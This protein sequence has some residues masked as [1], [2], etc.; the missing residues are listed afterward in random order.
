MS[1]V[2]HRGICLLLVLSMVLGITLIPN[3]LGITAG[4]AST[5]I[6]AAEE[7]ILPENIQDGCTLQCWNWSL[8][9][10]EANLG[11]IAN[12]GYTSIQ[13]SP[14][15]AVKEP[16]ENRP[17]N[18][19]WILYQPVE[20]TINESATHAIGTRDELIDLCE[21]A[22]KYGIKVIMDVVCNHMANDGDNVL[23]SLID[24]DILEDPLCWHD[25]TT[26]SWD[27]SSRYNITQYCM[28]GLPDL[29][30]ANAKIQNYCLN[31]LKDYIDCGVDG[32]RFDGAKQIETPSDDSSF[33]S[34]FWPTVVNGAT[35]YAQQTR[36][37]ALYCYGEIL[38]DADDNNSLP[39]SAYTDYMSVTD[40][41]WSN[42]VRY[43]INDQNAGGLQTSYFKNCNA[44]KLVLWGE[45][46]DTY[47]DGSSAGVSMDVIN[48]AYALVASRAYAMSLYYPRPN[49][50]STQELGQIAKNGWSSA[51]VK[52][53]NK[54]SNHF[55]G[56]SEYLTQDSYGNYYYNERGSSG[57]VIVNFYGGAREVDLPV[58]AMAA[59]SYVDQLTGNVFT[60][61]N[62]RITGQMG[63]AGV[64]IV[65]N[66]NTVS[67]AHASHGTD[68][69]CYDCYEYVGHSSGTTCSVCGTAAT[70]TFYFKNTDSWSTVNAYCWHDQGSEVT[71]GWPG[72]AMTAVSGNNGYYSITVPATATNV[73]FNNGGT[74]QT[75]D[76]T[77]PADHDAYDYST[78]FWS[79]YGEA[80]APD[81]Y[82]LHGS[83]NGAD[84]YDTDYVFT[85][86]KLITTFSATS[87]VYVQDS[88]GETYMTEGWQG[89]V[90]SVTL[91][92]VADISNDPN[93]L[94]V[95]A[96]VV[97]TLTL[98]E[99]VDGTLTLSYS[100]SDSACEHPYHSTAGVCLSCGSSVSHSYVDGICSCGK[101]APGSTRT[102]YFKNTANWATPHMYTWTDSTEYTGE[103][104]G[105]A[106][107]LVD[108]E[109]NI[110][111]LTINAEATKVS[112]NNGA[113][114][115]TN[116][117]TLPTNGKNMF[118]I[119]SNSWSTYTPAGS[120]SKDYYLFGYINGANYGCEEDHE[121]V[122]IYKFVNGS[123]TVTFESDSYVGI[124]TGDNATWYMTH[125]YVSSTSGM[126][127]NTA[128]GASE[129]M[130]IPGGKKVTLTLTVNSSGTL[131]L[132]YTAEVSCTHSYTATVTTAPGCTTAGVRTYTCSRCSDSYTESIAATGHTYS[133]GTCT[134][135]GAD[136]ASVTDYYLFGYINGSDYGCAEDYANMGIYKFVA[137]TLTT[138]FTKDSYVAV[139]EKDNKNWYM[140]NSYISTTSGT[141]Y[142]TSTGSGEK[143]FVPGG[144]EVTFTLVENSDGSLTLSY[145]T[146]GGC[147]H[148]YTA[149]I[150]T[151]PGCTTAG[152]RT[153]TC[154]TCGDSYT[155]SIA[156]TGHS[157]SSGFCTVCGG[158][159]PNYS[160][161]VDYYLF[162]YINGSDYAC[163]DD[164]ENLGIY[165]FVDGTLTVSFESDSYIGV[166]TGDGRWYMTKEYVPGNTGTFYNTSTGSMEKMFV[167]EGV[168]VT[169][170]LTVNADDTLTVSYTTAGGCDHSY[171][172]KVTIAP[173][174]SV[175]GIMT[176]TCSACGSSYTEHIS[177]TGHSYVNGVCA[178]CGAI[179]IQ[180]EYYLFGYI[181]G[182]N[183]GCEDDYEN[184]G[185]Y[186]FVDGTLKAT[187]TADS[188][189]AIKTEDNQSWYM[190]QTYVT[191]T[192]A[193]FYNTSTGTAEKMLV[194]GGVEVTF[195]LTVNAND[196]LTLSYTT[197]GGCVH[198]YNAAV[199][200]AP[201]CTA[202]GITTYTCS[203]CGSSYTEEI[204]ALNHSFVN[205]VCTRCGTAQIQQEYYLF[206]SINGANYGCE[207]DYENLGIYKF[208][209]GTLTATFTTDS[210]VGIKT[211]DNKNWYMTQTYVTDTTATFYHTATG[212]AEKMLVPG[213]VEYIFTLTVNGDGS[214][215]MSYVASGS[216]DHSYVAAITAV[217]GCEKDGVITYTC[218]KCAD[219][220]TESII[221]L[222][223][224][225]ANSYCTVCGQKD[226]DAVTV[227][228]LKPSYA[229]VS[230]EDEIRYNLY[231]TASD[232]EDV[233]ELGL[234]VFDTEP[235][236]G[237]IGN[238]T[239]VVKEY[240]VSDT[241][242]MAQSAGV[243]AKNMGDT[244]Y[245]RLYA[246][247]S[248]G[249]YVYSNTV[250]YSC[251]R[252]A[253]TIL[254]KSQSQYMKAL[255]V[256][257]LNYGAEAQLYFG[258]NTDNLM[259]AGL[260][261]EQQALVAAYD[262]DTMPNPDAVDSTK[263]GIFA[264]VGFGRSYI[265]ASFDS[266]FALNYYFSTSYVPDGDVTMYY[267][268]AKDY[269][270]ADT[271]SAANATGSLITTPTDT[272][273]QFWGNITG[274]AAKEMAET[275]YV[276]AVYI[277]GGVTYSTVVMNYS[278]GRYCDTVAAKN[279]SAQQAL[280]MATAVYG[281]SAKAY[282]DSL[283]TA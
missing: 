67:C 35:S 136:D 119:S 95:P 51:I 50:M 62:G 177:A 196:S 161:G 181:N 144:V 134:V 100:A 75:A 199:T 21:S 39:I 164:Y 45:S 90:T 182:A 110:Y 227:P 28:S 186:K 24:P 69:Y 127:F 12:L 166:R 112:F 40:S 78:G 226:P 225:Y 64:A 9:N 108:G 142:N 254:S 60:V 279:D 229:S 258:Y 260:T 193:T 88:N 202:S 97:V 212:T 155:E 66:P 240:S 20:F 255:V 221:A 233:A 102:V 91:K 268:T 158:A 59:G 7:S 232:M 213:G 77:A 37:I 19:W 173:S 44:D 4:A 99:N 34:N 150:T 190:T 187:F 103:W 117:L 165:K 53:A 224:D 247:L 163:E 275:I 272:A 73:I 264:N 194:P 172:S 93:K 6:N 96:N 133:G 146:A 270:A 151:A 23:C 201:T 245:F 141:F 11:L 84:Y 105:T 248:D 208:V 48:R 36:G 195:T 129:K 256:A 107:T 217:P 223:H 210:Y 143:M 251:V 204:A 276:G 211:S 237:V 109:T 246:R 121:N 267:W 273:N 111:E 149:S 29:N 33:A 92:K 85:N 8:A 123:L 191:D 125:S 231:F 278:M 13:I 43:R 104:P 238:A 176:Y 216:C 282:F 41:V 203:S 140:A 153:Y 250:S 241:Y 283:V 145:V 3:G 259:N 170:T 159:D 132:K 2:L 101:Y 61:S 234:L 89:E 25:Y 218:S 47:N 70:R 180:H 42:D 197:E 72:D 253:N 244:L 63:D 274:I 124:K 156:A 15:Q 271:L 139:K 76:L 152:V 122:G 16:T 261:E 207:D 183:Y 38:G 266:A 175:N 56:Q 174:C 113:S 71:S 222:G 200:A 80:D 236:D 169:F 171:T 198:S 115:K 184:L 243:A 57:I 262:A 58:Y 215:T 83:I 54:F 148:S 188:Y 206:G 87:Y 128:S 157:Y 126:F 228:T 14:L 167:P 30:T 192:T 138:S 81:Y 249:S 17:Y 79:T 1:R 22:H 214:L 27:Y 277:S 168:E 94:M 65:Y 116:D 118:V 98:T 137:G 263:N 219:S 147:T 55:V 235:T 68:G 281:A 5:V 209:N 31:L 265:T 46:H 242:Y 220:Y 252:Y 10:I 86:G 114:S 179:Q 49:D 205:G 26:N 257:M 154:S 130:L 52:A 162:G 280:S 178:F 189:I 269:A 230:F 131:T 32:F 106:M 135:C 18:N 74:V 120:S 82:Y 239:Y 160:S 185:V